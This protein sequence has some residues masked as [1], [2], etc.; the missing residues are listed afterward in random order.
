[1]IST[2]DGSDLSKQCC[3]L[4]VK[5]F[6]L[7]VGV[8]Y[9]PASHMCKSLSNRTLEGAFGSL[10]HAFFSSLTACVGE[11][12]PV[13]F[14]SFPACSDP[15]S[16]MHSPAFC[17]ESKASAS[18][19][20]KSGCCHSPETKVSGLESGRVGFAKGKKTVHSCPGLVSHPEAQTVLMNSLHVAWMLFQS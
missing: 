4:F 8:L 11:D 2:E 16:Q 3:C 10:Q 9:F 12:R 20:A 17:G 6:F 15:D 7:G 13:T 18:L 5:K 14:T 1:M 19:S